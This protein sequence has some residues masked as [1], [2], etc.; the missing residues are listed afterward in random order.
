MIQA[1]IFIIAMVMPDGKVEV[2]HTLVPKCPTKEEVSKT[3]SPLKERGEILAWGGSCNY[4]F[5]PREA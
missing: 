2:H 3:M 1:F 5:P 4:L